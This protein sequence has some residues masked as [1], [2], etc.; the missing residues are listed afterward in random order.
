MIL[1]KGRVTE[2]IGR[3]EY[4]VEDLFDQEI[5]NVT[6]SGKIKMEIENLYVGDEVYVIVSP[7]ET[8]RGRLPVA[9]SFKMDNDL[10]GQKIELDRKQREKNIK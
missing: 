2:K 8:N 9:S 6:L 3:F 10:F 7:F 1:R 5:I 4:L